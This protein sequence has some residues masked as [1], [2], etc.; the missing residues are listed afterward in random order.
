MTIYVTVR[1]FF[2]IFIYVSFEKVSFSVTFSSKKSSRNSQ[3]C[4]L[5]HVCSKILRIQ[6]EK[7]L[8]ELVVFAAPPH[9]FARLSGM[10]CHRPQLD[11]V[12]SAAV[13]SLYPKAS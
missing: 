9:N 1:F 2:Q 10:K 5:V 3:R 6:T 13:G 8:S 12:N 7:M 4:V 11:K